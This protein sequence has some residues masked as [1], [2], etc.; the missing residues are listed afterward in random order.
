M[1]DSMA[2]YSVANNKLNAI[3]DS[4]SSPSHG[5]VYVCCPKPSHQQVSVT[6]LFLHAAE[7]DT[8]W[9]LD[10]PARMF[11]SGLR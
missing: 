3:A 1:L 11:A 2:R 9:N 7:D 10:R 6:L 4:K 5:N 8:E